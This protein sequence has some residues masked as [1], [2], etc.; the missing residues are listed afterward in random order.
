MKLILASQSPRRKE[1]LSQLGVSFET[2]P[3]DIDETP[4]ASELPEEYV[5]RMA[6]EKAQVIS[7]R[8]PESWI[9]GSDT[10]VILDGVIMGKPENETDALNMLSS[11]SGKTHQ[12]LTAVALVCQQQ[13][14]TRL[15]STDVVFRD[16]S[17]ELAK[18]YWETGEPAD[19]AGSYGIQGMGGMLV[20]SIEGSYSSV[21]G[22][23]LAETADLLM[24]IGI[25]GWW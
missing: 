19:K 22:L 17:P 11:L 5:V 4:L 1:L 3:A 2:C 25:E 24:D 13:V 6:V 15:V 21:V 18:A 20:R 14:K 10:S 12:V 7:N 16:I 23:P 9:L 8:F